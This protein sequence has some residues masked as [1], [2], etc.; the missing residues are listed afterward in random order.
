[1]TNTAIGLASFA[2]PLALGCLIVA[3]V[4]I[5]LVIWLVVRVN[6]VEKRYTALLQG[7]DG[8]TLQTV[9]ESH[10]S[11]VRL[12]LAQVQA[13]AQ[14][15]DQVAEAACSHVQHVGLVRYNPFRETG[16]DQSYAL[17]LADGHGNG[18]VLT[19]LHMRDVTRV[20][21]KPLENWTSAYPLTDEEQRALR[22]ARGTLAA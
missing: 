6:R 3:L 2:G 1:M 13:L 4:L 16:G 17:V 15:T 12:A 7:T 8:G 10:V 5:A 11:E 19:S 18:A 14:R 22:V 20:Y 21:A 9:L